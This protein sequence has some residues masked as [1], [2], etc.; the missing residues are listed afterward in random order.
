MTLGNLLYEINT[1]Y[2]KSV[3]QLEGYEHIPAVSDFLNRRK[4]D[5]DEFKKLVSG[6][7]ITDNILS[8]QADLRRRGVEAKFY[9]G[10]CLK[11]ADYFKKS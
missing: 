7:L 1:A 8:V 3:E 11:G 5:M 10:I 6:Y 4:K 2:K 9:G